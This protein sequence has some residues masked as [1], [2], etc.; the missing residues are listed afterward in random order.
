[1][2]IKVNYG[3]F[4]MFFQFKCFGEDML[5]IL[6]IIGFRIGNKN[7]IEIVEKIDEV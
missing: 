4:E 7:Y 6:D 5:V 3:D 1:M 2:N